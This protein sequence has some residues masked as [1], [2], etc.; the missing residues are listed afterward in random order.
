MWDPNECVAH[1]QVIGVVVH[2][3]TAASLGGAAVPAPVMGDDPVPVPQE[4]QQLGVPVISRQ[5]PP[6]TE[7][8]RLARAPV[9]VEDLRT[10]SRR[11]RAHGLPPS[12][13]GADAGTS[14][15][16]G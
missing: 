12:V 13:G 6:V 16:T 1:P 3:V 2:V 8:H 9:L 10:I 11:N 4:E 5:R 15:L 14:A 7:H